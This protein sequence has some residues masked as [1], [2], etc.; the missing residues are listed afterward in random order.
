MAVRQLAMIE[1]PTLKEKTRARFPSR[2]RKESDISQDGFTNQRP[3][4]KAQQENKTYIHIHKDV[5]AVKKTEELV[6]SVSETRAGNAK[7][8]I[9]YSQ[10]NVS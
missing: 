3:P 5:F 2:E 9:V 10:Q 7:V 1:V 8:V 6:L 4:S